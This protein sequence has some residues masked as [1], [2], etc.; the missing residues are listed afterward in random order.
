MRTLSRVT[1]AGLLALVLSAGPSALSAHADDTLPEPT[2]PSKTPDPPTDGTTTYANAQFRWS[3][4]K[5]LHITP[6]FGVNFLTAGKIADTDGA[7]MSPGL[8]KVSEG[9]VRIERA[10]DKKYGPATW[11]GFGTGADHQVVI[12][13][14]SGSVNV[15]QKNARIQWTGSFGVARYGGMTAF[16]VSDPVLTVKNGV[17]QVSATLSGFGVQREG[18]GSSGGTGPL[19]P[20][21]V[22]LANLGPVDLSNQTGIRKAPKF[23]GVRVDH[24]GQV[25]DTKGRFGSFPAS[26]I[27]FVDQVGQAE[28]W[29]TSGS[30][31][32]ATA[33]SDVIISYDATKPFAVSP[34][35]PITGTVKPPITNKTKPAPKHRPKDKPRNV[36]KQ[37]PV[38]ASGFPPPSTLAA[39]LVTDVQPAAFLHS[40]P[41]SLSGAQ[42]LTTGPTTG[43]P[44]GLWLATSFLLM[45]AFAIVIPTL[46]YPR[47]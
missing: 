6:H 15:D 19:A 4:N 25:K 10:A 13:G 2:A 47:S 40:N 38:P 22:V 23:Y 44:I 24:R 11:A 46:I 5:L 12:D 34:P 35:P 7:A 43:S 29:M 36:A 1:V 41:T 8:W 14:G 20:E 28:F 3:L 30:D 21:N 9:A 16:S 42:P 37:A 26:F 27:K 31:D 39:P 18:M 17:G 33:P 45:A 32:D